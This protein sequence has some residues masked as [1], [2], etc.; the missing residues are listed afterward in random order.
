MESP[1]IPRFFF[2]GK[3]PLGQGER[4][5]RG[6]A[7]ARREAEDPREDRPLRSDAAVG[8]GS[9]LRSLFGAFEHHQ[10]KYLLE[11]KSPMVG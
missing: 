11:I 2:A 5:R 1:E 6:A 8:Q 3:Q 9:G 4:P 10:N 7:T